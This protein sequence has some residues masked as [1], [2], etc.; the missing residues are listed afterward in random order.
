LRIERVPGLVATC[1]GGDLRL[2][3]TLDHHG[4]SIPAHWAF[5]AN[6]ETETA[7]THHPSQ[8]WRKRPLA[9]MQLRVRV[10]RS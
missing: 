7:A 1:G 4:F 10:R 8:G 3:P 5:A 6:L 9:T 2:I